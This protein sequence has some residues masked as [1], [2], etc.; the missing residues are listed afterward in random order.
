M[1]FLEK[2]YSSRIIDLGEGLAKIVSDNGRQGQVIGLF[3][4]QTSRSNQECE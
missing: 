1:Y 4:Q 2:V 3:R